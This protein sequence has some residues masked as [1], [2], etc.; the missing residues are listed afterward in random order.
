ML[1]A[2][3]LLANRYLIVCKVGQ[4]GMGAVYKAVDTRLGHRLCA[5][6]EMS[7]AGLSTMAERQLAV[8]KFEQEAKML[9]SLNHPNLP[10]VSDYFS[11]GGRHYMVM[12]FIE[13]QTLLECLDTTGRPMPEGEVRSIA[14]QLCEVLYY[15][16]NQNPPVI[17]RDMKPGNVMLQSDGRVKLIDFGIIRFFQYGK[18]QDTQFLGTPGFAAPEAYGQRQTDARS[19]IYSLGMTLYCLLTAKEPPQTLAGFSP[20]G[21]LAACASWE[22]RQVLSKA[23]EIKPDTRWGTAD[24]MRQALGGAPP[25]PAAGGAGQPRA[26]QAPAGGIR[27][28][29]QHLTRTIVLK[30]RQMSNAQLAATV[31]ALVAGVG[32][33]TWLV[34]PWI[35]VN[36]PWLWKFLPLYYAGGPFAYAVSNRKG[37]IALV[38][39]PLQIIVGALTWGNASFI[40]YLLTALAGAAGM[41][42][43]LSF[44]G[45]QKA[46]VWHYV[47]APALGV[48]VSM[49]AVAAAFNSPFDP[50]QIMGAG[51]AGAIAYAAGE[52]VWGVR[53]GL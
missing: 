15:L 5:V 12:E 31:A 16:H 23:L 51:V 27:R 46:T 42:G 3:F 37:A 36:L 17:F 25:A 34:G 32:L 49:G 38:H 48:A 40:Q 6:K 53:Q 8:A 4:G 41:E 45:G 29:T 24:E 20:G 30:M 10:K 13:G 14:V 9:A 28:A 33:S 1:P 52:A 11:E 19:D 39:V 22:L 44:L 18:K 50:V 2:N 35:E 21:D 26:P 7:G 47:A 43:L